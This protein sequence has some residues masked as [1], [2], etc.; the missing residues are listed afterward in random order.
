MSEP[1]S[2]RRA[3]MPLAVAVLL[4]AGPAIAFAEAPERSNAPTAGAGTD[5]EP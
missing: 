4:M 1:R 5:R 3:V 2:F